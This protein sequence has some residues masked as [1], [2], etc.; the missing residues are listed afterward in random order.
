MDQATPAYQGFL[1][2]IRECRQDTGVDSNIRLR[3]GRDYQKANT[4]KVFTLHN[5]TNFERDH[6]REN[7]YFSSTYGN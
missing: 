4:S 7:A 6:I 1:R 2:N 5:S 3:A